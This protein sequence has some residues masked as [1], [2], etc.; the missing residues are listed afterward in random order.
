MVRG[1]RI[2]RRNIIWIRHGIGGHR[3][4][5]GAY[6]P[7]WWTGRGVYRSGIRHRPAGRVWARRCAALGIMIRRGKHRTVGTVRIII[8]TPYGIVSQR[9][10]SRVF[11][12]FEGRCLKNGVIFRGFR[13]RCML[14][15]RCGGRNFQRLQRRSIG[16]RVHPG[17]SI[18]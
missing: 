15:G 6:C 14:I 1:G 12:L 9:G 17:G 3:R 2:R 5:S 4:W 10:H 8:T 11:G 13:L 16:I 18:Y 7:N